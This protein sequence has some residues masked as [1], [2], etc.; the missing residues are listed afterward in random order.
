[1]LKHRHMPQTSQ[2]LLSLELPCNDAAPGVVRA[3]LARVGALRGVLGDITLVASEIVTNAVQH[4]GCVGDEVLAVK[5]SQRRDRMLIS[6]RDPGLSG[7]EVRQRAG[8]AE[9]GPGGWGL[10]I[11]EQLSLRWGA[12]RNGGYHVWA[13]I[14]IPS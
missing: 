14:A 4:S 7:R 5:A 8:F 3:A 9:G 13:E 6:V 11:V 1:M 12:E 2:E 10:Q